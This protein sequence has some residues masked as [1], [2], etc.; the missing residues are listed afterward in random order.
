MVMLMA[1]VMLMLMVMVKD[2]TRRRRVCAPQACVKP[3]ALLQPPPIM[4]HE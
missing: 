3:N 2:C 1:T 4:H